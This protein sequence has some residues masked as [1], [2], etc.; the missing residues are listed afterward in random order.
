MTYKLSFFHLVQGRMSSGEVVYHC[1]GKVCIIMHTYKQCC[2]KTVQAALF[3]A[4]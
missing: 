3:L 2:M 4:F 1:I